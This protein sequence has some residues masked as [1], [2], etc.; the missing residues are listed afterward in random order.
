MILHRCIAWPK[1][2]HLIAA[3]IG[4]TG[5]LGGSSGATGI[6]TSTGAGGTCSA[7]GAGPL[8]PTTSMSLSDSKT[9]LH[10]GGAIGF[11]RRCQTDLRGAAGAG[12]GAGSGAGLAAGAGAGARRCGMGIS[13]RGKIALRVLS[14]HASHISTYSGGVA[15]WAS[16]RGGGNSSAKVWHNI[17][18]P[19]SRHSA[20]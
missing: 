16:S 4:N 2:T 10:R 18:K 8:T 7:A 3:V 1:G 12:R 17:H 15:I 20:L 11:V 19:P 13:T 6:A 14:F 5:S 9:R